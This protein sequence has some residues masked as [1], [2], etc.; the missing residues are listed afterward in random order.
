MDFLLSIHPSRF[1]IAPGRFSKLHPVSVQRW[2]RYILPDRSK[3]AGLCVRVHRRTSHELVLAPQAVSPMSCSF[4]LMV[5]E[6]RC[7]RLNGCSFFLELLNV[8]CKILVQFQL[9]FFSLSFLSVP[10]V[11]PENSIDTNTVWKK[12]GFILSD[13][14]D[15]LIIDSI[16]LGAYKHSFL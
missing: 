3:L 7:K 8:A 14:W 16:S 4:Y 6:M 1:S 11:H 10:V 13:R 2:Y 12:T 15:L 9:I 5:L